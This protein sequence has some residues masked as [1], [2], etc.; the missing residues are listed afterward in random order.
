[1]REKGT[2]SCFL[3]TSQALHTIPLRLAVGSVFI[4]H[5]SQKLFGW[6]GGHGFQATAQA[7]FHMGLSSELALMAGCGEFFGGLLILLGL[8]TRL[9]ALS[10]GIVMLVAIFKVH[11]GN[12]FLPKGMEY[13][14][15]LLGIAASLFISGGGAFSV[16]GCLQR[17]HLMDSNLRSAI[18]WKRSG[19]A[20]DNAC[21]K[22]RQ[23]QASNEALGP[24][25][26][27]S[28][29]LRPSPALPRAMDKF[30]SSLS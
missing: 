30:P 7:F 4:A 17:K 12:F 25:K 19:I 20:P 26:A 11:R 29:A 13:A 16:D 10:I 18:F 15:T 23:S 27:G 28:I 5:G 1:M 3:K 6:F 2:M 24:C 9:G 14:L 8:L 22:L 21:S